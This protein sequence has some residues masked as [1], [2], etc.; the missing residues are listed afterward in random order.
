VRKYLVQVVV[1]D[2]QR[3]HVGYGARSD[4][5]QK[6]VAVADLDQEAGRGLTATRSRHAGAA[7]NDPYLVF[8]EFLGSRVIHIAVWRG[9]F[10]VRHLAA[11]RK[12]AGTP[13]QYEA[14]EQ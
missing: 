8:S 1:G 3:R 14:P 9:P 6:L 10:R 13:R 4:I 11:G 12:G 2:H 5:E 7:G